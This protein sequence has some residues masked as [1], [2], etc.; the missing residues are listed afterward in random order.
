MKGV[1]KASNSRMVTGAHHGYLT[2]KL[3]THDK[4]Q[5]NEGEVIYHTLQILHEHC[6]DV[7]RSAPHGQRLA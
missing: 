1:E 4:G 5:T 2:Q 7:P 3:A 6:E